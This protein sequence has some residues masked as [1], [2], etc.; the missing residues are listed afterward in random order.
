MPNNPS[1][2][3]IVFVLQGAVVDPLLTIYLINGI[4]AVLGG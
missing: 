2:A 3:G 1:L 4:Q